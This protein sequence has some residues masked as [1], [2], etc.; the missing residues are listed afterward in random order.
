MGRPI[1]FI[2]F[3]LAGCLS[4]AQTWEI[5]DPST[6]GLPTVTITDLAEDS[7]GNMWVGTEWGLCKYDGASWTI[8]QS[9]NSG[10]PDNQ[11]TAVAVDTADNV[12]VGSVQGGLAVFDGVSTW[13]YYNS[14]NSP[15]AD[16]QVTCISIDHRNWVWVGTYLGLLCYT[17][18]EWRLYNDQ[19]TSYNGLVP[20]GTVIRD[21]AVRE[22]DGLVA[23]GTLNGGFHYMSESMVD[24]HATYI[25]LF[26]DNTQNGVAFDSIYTDRWLATPSQGLIR[27]FGDWL[28]G[29]FFQYAVTNSLIPSNSLLCLAMDGQGR[30]WVRSVD[31]GVIV[32]N[33]D[34]TFVSYGTG[35]SPMPD[36]GVTCLRWASDGS[37]WIGTYAGGAVR[38]TPTAGSSE[39]RIQVSV[40]PNPASDHC[41]VT[42]PSMNGPVQWTLHSTQ[43]SQ[44][45]AG[46]SGSSTFSIN[47]QG[48]QGGTYVLAVLGSQGRLLARLVK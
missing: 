9:D 26:F 21:V 45:L 19:P 29:F 10:L 14:A 34:D 5:F 3:L 1:A 32:R 24:V 44:V 42:I 7:Q 41:S 36:D 48:I 18:S 39:Q 25:D 17:G 30:P 22:S 46:S 28:G 33:P 6:A 4:H 23:I 16:D 40:H 11:V 8:W 35:N 31:A 12:W 15:L 13:T 2:G 37:L 38:M 43:G 47:M 27:N 20:N